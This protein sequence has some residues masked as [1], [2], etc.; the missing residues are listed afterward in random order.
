MAAFRLRLTRATA[1][2][3]R[4]TTRPPG[5]FRRMINQGSLWPILGVLALGVG[6]GVQLGESAVGDIDPVHFQGA[7]PPP[8]AVAAPAPVPP[9]PYV[10]ATSWEQG[11]AAR[12]ADSGYEDFDFAPPALAPRQVAAIEPEWREPPPPA[13][14]V[15]WPPGRTAAHP[16]VERY[17]DFPIARKPLSVRAPA[18][19]EEETPPETEPAE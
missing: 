3:R 18:E 17:T 11:Q 15:P 19:E 7:A 4:G 2:R 10:Q 12:T 9:S 1:M 14:L 5:R 8:R 16:E 13:S 6:A